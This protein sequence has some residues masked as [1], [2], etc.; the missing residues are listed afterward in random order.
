[1]KVALITDALGLNNGSMGLGIT[2][3]ALASGIDTSLAL[4]GAS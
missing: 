2:R 1:M 3:L 4:W